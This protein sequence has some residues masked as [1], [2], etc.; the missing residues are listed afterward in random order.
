MVLVMG[1]TGRTGGAAA[2][3]FFRKMEPVRVLIRSEGRRQEMEDAGYEVVIGDLTRDSDVR[4]AMDGVDAVY[5]VAPQ[6]LDHPDP[7]ALELEIG[8]RVVDAAKDA[9]VGH[10]IYLSV[11]GVDRKTGIPHFESK[12]AIEKWILDAGLAYTFLR[13]CSFMENF[14]RQK[15]EILSGTLTGAM[16]PSIPLS[17]V[18]VEDIGRAAAAAYTWKK[19]NRAYDLVGPRGVTFTEVAAAFSL[20]LGKPVTYRHLPAR[21]WAEGAK[22]FMS[23]KF[24][25]DLAMMFERYNDGT[26]VGKPTAMREELGVEPTSI[27]GYAMQKVNIWK[28][29]LTNQPGILF[30]PRAEAAKKP[31]PET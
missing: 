24:A 2:A 11:F 15:D 9:C 20:A 12:A 3:G 6:P 22:A 13:P 25:D 7:V 14:D 23:P 8:R 19:K 21:Q 10:L 28:G 17:I 27:E 31:L 29:I 18:S 30:N 5:H 1:A 16:M 26:F 4:R